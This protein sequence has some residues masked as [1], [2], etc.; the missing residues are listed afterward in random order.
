MQRDV[1]EQLASEILRRGEAAARDAVT[2]DPAKPR[3][4]LIQPAPGMSPIRS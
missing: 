3:L 4:D 1:L 2:F